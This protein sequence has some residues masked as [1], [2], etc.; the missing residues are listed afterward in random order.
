[1]QISALF[2]FKE[3]NRKLPLGVELRARWPGLRSRRKN[4]TARAP[5]LFFSRKCTSSIAV[6]FHECGSGSSAPFFLACG[7]GSSASL[8]HYWGS[9]FCSFSQIN[10]FKCLGVPQVE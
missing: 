4:D 2:L 1:M 3:R 10:I 6:D 7:S 5:D 9:G 8:F